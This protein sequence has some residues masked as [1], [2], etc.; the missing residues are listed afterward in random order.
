MIGEYVETPARKGRKAKKKTKA[1]LLMWHKNFKVT[2]LRP[3][4]G[5]TQV[6]TNIATA[7]EGVSIR[8]EADGDSQHDF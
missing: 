8:S 5:D 2:P 3:S 7:A 6:V 4:T 1:F